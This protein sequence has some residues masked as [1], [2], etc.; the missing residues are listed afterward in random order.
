ASTSD[1]DY[2]STAGTLTF[3]PG[4]TSC[5]FTVTVCGDNR[6]E[7]DETFLVQL[8]SPTGADVQD[9]VG[10]GTIRNDDR[11]TNITQSSNR[12][13]TVRPRRAAVVGGDGSDGDWF[14]LGAG[15]N[16]AASST[17]NDSP[18]IALWQVFGPV[19]TAAEPP[20]SSTFIDD[21]SEESDSR[22][23]ESSATSLSSPAITSTTSTPTIE[24]SL[25]DDQFEDLAADL[26]PSAFEDSESL[27]DALV[28]AS[29]LADET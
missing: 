13:T 8:Y 23:I 7:A 21:A 19:Q 24:N 16:F 17:G 27:M 15:G 22:S 12:N 29:V 14:V 1:R 2:L 25:L 18:M 20:A 11:Q 9:S 6:V 28:Q 4:Q 26:I 5:Q 10:I 3:A